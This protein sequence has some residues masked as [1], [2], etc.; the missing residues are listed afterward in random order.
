MASGL[1]G[2]FH[3]ASGIVPVGFWRFAEVEERLI[4]AMEVLLRSPDRERRWLGSQTQAIWRMVQ[5]D[6]GTVPADDKPIITCA[7]T[8]QQVDLADQALEWI[9]RWVPSGDTRRVVACGLGQLVADNARIDWSKV[10]RQMGGQRAGW[11]TDGLRK[12][13]NRAIT[14]ICHRLNASASAA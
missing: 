2:T 12:R 7:F 10:W 14:T 5:D 3:D 6:L 4:E 11:T 9:A 13:Y 1:D 8:R